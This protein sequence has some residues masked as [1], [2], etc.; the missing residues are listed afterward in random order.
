MKKYN[1]FILEAKL[2]DILPNQVVRNITPELNDDKDFNDDEPII[3]E[4]KSEKKPG[5]VITINYYNTDEHDILTK[6]K[7]R[8]DL[9]STHEFNLIVKGVVN[10]IFPHNMKIFNPNGRYVL[11]LKENNFKMLIDFD[12]VELYYHHTLKII[13]VMSN[14][15]TANCLKTFLIEDENFLI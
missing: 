8:T 11:H 7:D 2:R 9:I 4:V 15:A 14:S 13:T 6:I 12:M 3:T 10:L 1:E 5:T